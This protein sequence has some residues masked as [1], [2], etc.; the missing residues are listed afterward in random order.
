VEPAERA[1]PLGCF[2]PEHCIRNPTLAPETSIGHRDVHVHVPLAEK[3]SQMR[4]S[5]PGDRGISPR[6]WTRHPQVEVL[7]DV[8][9]SGGPVRGVFGC[10]LLLHR[11]DGAGERDDSTFHA[12]DDPVTKKTFLPKRSVD[13]FLDL[14]VS[15]RRGPFHVRESSRVYARRHDSNASSR[16]RSTRRGWSFRKDFSLTDPK[17]L[18]GLS[19][20]EASARLRQEGYNEIASAGGRGIFAIVREIVREPMILLLLAAGTIYLFLGDLREAIVLLLSVFVVIGISL[21]QNRRTERALAALRDLASPRAL[22]VRGGRRLRIAGR[23]VVRG[24]I[25]LLSEGDRVPAD[26]TLLEVT[27]LTADESLLTGES[28]PVRKVAS[29]ATAA[30]ARPGGDDQPFVYSGTLVVSGCAIARAEATGARTELGKIGRSLQTIVTE[31]TRLQKET[32]RI[33]RRVAV[34][35]ISLC[36]TVVIL[37]GL[38][39]ES[40]L[41]GFLAGLALAMAVLP[42]E[43]PVVLTIF[44]ALGAWRIS[45]RR[46]LTRRLPA[47][48][49]LGAAT[50]LCVDKTGTLTQNRMSVQKLSAAEAVYEVSGQER[51]SLP[52]QFHELLE[53]GILAS[54]PEA[55]DPMEQAIQGLGQRMLPATGR[56][57]DG[58][59]FVREYP[60]STQV[61][62]M[63][64]VF[65]A[66]DRETCVVA[67]KGA[68][69]A[70]T[71]L[72]RIDG[73]E[74]SRLTER[75]RVLAEEGL[76]VLG[77]ARATC[78]PSKLPADQREFGFEFVGLIALADPV[79]PGVPE[80]IRECH[81]A[82][83]RVVMIT[84]DYPVTAANIA[85]QIGLESSGEVSVITG[86]ELETLD[87]A[88]LRRRLGSAT[89]FARMV[90]DQKLR[91]VR[92]LKANGEVVAMTG[93][94]VNDAP[95]LKAADMGIAMG[96]RGTDVARE[97]ADLVLLD[98]DFSSI[99]EAVKMGR[100][101]FD[102]LRKAVAYILAIHVP[103][104][105]MSL[106]PVLLGWPLVLLPVHI[107]FLELII[108]PACSLAFEAEKEE[109]D[110]MR[111]PPRAPE[112]PL[113]SRRAVGIA[114]LQ[115]VGV[116]AI[117]FAVFAIAL[118]R[119]QG[120]E[121]ARTLAFTTL[122][123]ANLALILANRS[124]SR[125]IVQSLRS[126]N[127]ALVWVLGGA[128]ALLALVLSVPFLRDLFRFSKLHADDIVIS[129][130]AGL[131]SILW[132]EAFKLFQ[133]K[134]SSALARGRRAR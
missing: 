46:V 74:S 55:F 12:N 86:P 70:I 9:H 106:L 48:E 134:K 75:V 77:V 81:A 17:S 66:P 57:R 120:A 122:I 10:D 42:E 23:E 105:G 131:L 34:V 117:V 62:A 5:R 8:E 33:V 85:R 13:R 93:D 39:R 109:A 50:V 25:L 24:D 118:A 126:R 88:D 51:E 111:R 73:S 38:I 43:F 3:F 67:A 95:A 112:E 54:R 116:L 100:R 132:F 65:R 44:L 16:K 52:Q 121:D 35:A 61:L 96:E 15:F 90:P 103:I 76:R 14:P 69:E 128:A 72:C 68:P 28:V 41:D 101:I 31:K 91:L 45:R 22:V 40:W 80:A 82:G 63:S 89:V 108:D 133:R 129:V 60:L 56:L 114:L 49:S 30:P 59:E 27:N 32:D 127:A 99:V 79:R 115:G 119:G 64:R 102:N 123:V 83:I 113:F 26:A 29:N 87:E 36:L 97:A 18:R 2:L 58:W 4:A 53:L 19:E 98:D 37:Y 92:A 6:G 20:D 125:T 84:G 78:E 124:W 47:I 7:G 107:V 21:Y 1:Q 94:G 104:A 130:A 110:V 71:A 11:A